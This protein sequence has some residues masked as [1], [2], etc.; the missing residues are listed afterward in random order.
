[1]G[2]E[3][4]HRLHRRGRD[5]RQSFPCRQ[6]CLIGI[7]QVGHIGGLGILADDLFG[8]VRIGAGDL[9]AFQIRLQKSPRVVAVGF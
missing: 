6:E 1:M 2:G 4:E 7:L 8:V 3:I 5:Q 9:D